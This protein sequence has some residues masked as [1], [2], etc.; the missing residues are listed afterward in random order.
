MDKKYYSVF[1]YAKKMGVTSQTIYN[2][3]KS[4]KLESIEFEIGSVGKK[5]YIIV[6]NNE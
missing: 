5:G 1:T 4:G 2:Q 3:I 6:E